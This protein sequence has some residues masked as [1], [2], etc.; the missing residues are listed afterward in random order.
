MFLELDQVPKSFV[1]VQDQDQ[2]PDRAR[3]SRVN[4]A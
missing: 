4:L 1:W 2:H 3:R